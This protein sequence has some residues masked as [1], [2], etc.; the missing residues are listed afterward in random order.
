MVS[1]GQLFCS[2]PYVVI[3]AL[4]DTELC[5]QALTPAPAPQ[6]F[7][8]RHVIRS[9]SP[10]AEDDNLVSILLKINSICNH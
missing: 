4:F 6:S 2:Q 7:S 8:Q 3:T 9:P 1:F 5:A 10:L